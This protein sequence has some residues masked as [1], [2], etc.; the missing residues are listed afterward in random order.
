M[1][2]YLGALDRPFDSDDAAWS[3]DSCRRERID[4]RYHDPGRGQGVPVGRRLNRFVIRGSI[5]VGVD[6]E[7]RGPVDVRVPTKKLN[8]TPG[9]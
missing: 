8:P 6:L 2:G 9:P 3:T 5:V 4:L 1:D 7:R